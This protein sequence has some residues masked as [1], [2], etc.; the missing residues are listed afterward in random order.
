MN[1]LNKFPERSHI[2]MVH[3]TKDTSGVCFF[4][5]VFSFSEFAHVI[6]CTGMNRTD[7]P[8][9]MLRLHDGSITVVII[10]QRRDAGLCHR[11]VSLQ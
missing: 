1:Y 11:N 9:C 2:I 3:T 4:F 5:D 8:T 6:G 7:K 10:S